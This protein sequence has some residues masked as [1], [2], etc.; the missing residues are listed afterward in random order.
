MRK[1]FSW[2]AG[3]VFLLC[4]HTLYADDLTELS[5]ELKKVK[6]NY[7]HRIKALE[8]RIA[9][10]EKRKNLSQTMPAAQVAS[11]RGK[12][13]APLGQSA[14]VAAQPI[15]PVPQARLTNPSDTVNSERFKLGLSTLFSAGGSSANDAEL[16]NL[17][18]GGHDP[19]RNGFTL[20]NVEL[21]ITGAVDPYINGYAHLIFMINRGG[22][23]VVELEEAFL[24]TRALPYGLQVKSGQ[25]FTEFG[26]HNPQHPHSWAF[27]DQPVALSRF[28]GGDG[29]R[30]QGVRLSWLTPLPWFSEFTLG[31]QNANGET[32]TSFLWKPAEQI[33]GY[34]LIDRGGV[35]SAD[36]LLWSGRW[37]NGWDLSPTISAN[38]GVSALVG[39]NASGTNT[40]TRIGG[41]DLYLKWRP[42]VNARG[43]PFVSWQTE[44]LARNYE[45][46]G[47]TLNDTGAYTQLLWG[48]RPRWVAGLRAEYAD[49][50]AS[51]I[52]D[53]LRDKRE[54]YSANLSFYS[55]EY[56]KLRLQY[57][58]D[59]AEHL[60]G[61]TADSVWLQ[62]E[63]NLGAHAAHKF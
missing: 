49:G 13:I 8:Q 22:E 44:W 14:P 52:S 43:F 17:Q 32:L 36:D 20:Q 2:T 40:N 24:T 18:A 7:E 41:L 12:S 30:S 5:K 31:A 42:V 19:S 27:V 62:F 3:T 1:L 11:L 51:G 25:Y 60:L 57:N 34:T 48:F 46:P 58:H 6:S 9:D 56:S 29:L 35:R 10:L 26:R 53:P 4:S 23:T 33:G 28:F 55:T 59:R 21:S 54:R 50:N 47:A 39:P 37:L 38:L 61:R 16:A 15:E 63:F 45:T